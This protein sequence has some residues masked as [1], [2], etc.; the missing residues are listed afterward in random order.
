MPNI[1][2]D[3]DVK[4]AISAAGVVHSPGVAQE[5]MR[6][7]APFLAEEGIDLDDLGDTDLDTVNAA[8]ARATTRYNQTLP[9]A[10]TTA[11]PPAGSPTH[12]RTIC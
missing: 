6:D 5:V 9:D 11:A 7:L 4:A 2:D 1:F 10:R 3:P 12:V 8:L